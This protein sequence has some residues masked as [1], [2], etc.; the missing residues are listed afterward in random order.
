MKFVA[1]FLAGA[2]I[3]AGVAMAASPMDMRKVRKKYKCAKR[4]IKNII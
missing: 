4:A 2:S 3:V 1:G